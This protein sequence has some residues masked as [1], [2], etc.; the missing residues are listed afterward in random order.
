MVL[1]KVQVGKNLCSANL[2]SLLEAIKLFIFL[3]T[4]LDECIDAK[5]FSYDYFDYGVE[6][7]NDQHLLLLII[8]V[9]D[10]FVRKVEFLTSLAVDVLLLDEVVKEEHKR[11]VASNLVL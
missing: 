3:L 4:E 10:H 9:H 7:G 5:G 6:F 2:S 11:T 1:L 8:Q